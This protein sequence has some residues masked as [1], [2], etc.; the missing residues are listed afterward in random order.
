MNIPA[1]SVEKGMVNGNRS[2]TD[3]PITTLAFFK[4][5]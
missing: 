4:E 3:V 5:M 2:L 1:V